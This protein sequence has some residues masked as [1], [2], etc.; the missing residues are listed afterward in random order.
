[1]T[2]R[3]NSIRSIVVDDLL[4]RMSCGVS[5][6]KQ[7]LRAMTCLHHNL[8]VLQPSHTFTLLFAK[9]H[10]AYLQFPPKPST[11][12]LYIRP[13]GLPPPSQVGRVPDTI[14]I[15]IL[16]T[17]MVIWWLMLEW[18]TK[19]WT[20][21]VFVK[22]LMPPLFPYTPL[23]LLSLSGFPATLFLS[24]VTRSCL[25]KEL[26]R[27]SFI[28]LLSS[29]SPCGEKMSFTE[30]TWVQLASRGL[31]HDYRNIWPSQWYGD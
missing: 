5:R 26:T 2:A 14:H 30:A 23:A 17:D 19:A 22:A 16:N 27:R 24:E 8:P 20:F 6:G 29:Y 7:L 4:R 28:F 18:R 13:V 11:S 9:L 31:C 25:G 10:L 12:P 21:S 3:N 1:M 15:Y